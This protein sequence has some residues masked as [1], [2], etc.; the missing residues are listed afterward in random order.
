MITNGWGLALTD[1]RLCGAPHLELAFIPKL[2]STR[3]Q[4]FGRVITH[5]EPNTRNYRE[6]IASCAK[7]R[8]DVEEIRH[9]RPVGTLRE[10]A[11]R[12]RDCLFP[13]N[14]KK[15]S[16]AVGQLALACA[17]RRTRH[18]NSLPV[19]HLTVKAMLRF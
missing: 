9:R 13:I 14:A 18:L 15:V 16:T 7:V 5:P 2:Q 11:C 8:D 10:R 12:L 4:C 17:T 19:R 6:A 1:C 3:G